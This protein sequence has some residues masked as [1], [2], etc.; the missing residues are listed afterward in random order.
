MLRFL[1]L[2]RV[3]IS[4]TQEEIGLGRGG[5]IGKK[6][7]EYILR[8]LRLPRARIGHAQQV[9]RRGVSVLGFGQGLQQGEALIRMAAEGETGSQKHRGLMVSRRLVV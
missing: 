2:R 3:V 1:E 5:A 8:L 7:G 4:V 6:P 9:E